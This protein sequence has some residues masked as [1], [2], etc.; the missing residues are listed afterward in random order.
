MPECGVPQP[1]IRGSIRLGRSRT[2]EA[3]RLPH[4]A[5]L[6]G[7]ERTTLP[8]G[9]LARGKA[10][11]KRMHLPVFPRNEC[12]P[13]SRRNEGAEG[14]GLA[15]TVTAAGAASAGGGRT[16]PRPSISG[17]C[18]CLLT[19]SPRREGSIVTRPL[20]GFLKAP[21]ARP[22]LRS[23]GPVGVAGTAGCSAKGT[24]AV[25]RFPRRTMR[26][27]CWQS[28]GWGPAQQTGFLTTLEAG[29]PH[30]GVSGVG[31][32]GAPSL[33]CQWLSPPC[34]LTSPC[35]CVS[36]SPLLTGTPVMLD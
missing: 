9:Q 16:R 26:W 3:S 36:Q 10:L 32:L 8:A 31:F 19:F 2:R 28:Q 25:T 13:P 24:L 22:G 14:P 21:E 15:R 27:G 6:P 34:V 30:P 35:V 23:R 12:I 1:D 33:A 5:G 29:V 20:W 17:A 18:L 4:V 11:V 7:E